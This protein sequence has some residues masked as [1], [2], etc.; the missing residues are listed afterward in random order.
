[1]ALTAAAAGEPDLT[2][3]VAQTGED[4]GRLARSSFAILRALEDKTFR[5]AFSAGPS[6]PWDNL[7]PELQRP[8]VL[9][10]PREVYHIA[11]ALIAAGDPD[12]GLRALHNLV[13]LQAEDGSWPISA[14]ISGGTHWRGLALDQL[15]LPILLAWRLGVADRLDFDPYPTLIRPAAIKILETGPATEFDRWDQAARL[16]PSSVGVAVAGLLVAAEFA[17]DAHEPAASDHME[18]VADYWNSQIETWC[19]SKP[20]AAYVTVDA[21]GQ[22]SLGVE[23]LDLVRYGLRSPVDPKV[24]AS[25]DAVDAVLK[26][27]TPHG[28]AWKRYEG[29]RYGDGEDGRPWDGDGLG[30][31]WPMLTAERAAYGVTAGLVSSRLVRAVEQFGGSIGVLP[32]QVWDGPD[33]AGWGLSHGGP[34]SSAAPYGAAHAQYLKLLAAIAQ[35]QSPDLIEPVQ[36][37]YAE[38]DCT[39]APVIWSHRNLV[40]RIPQGRQF[41]VQLPRQAGVWFSVDGGITARLATSIDTS[42]GFWTVDLPLE[43]P[44][45]GTRLEWTID[46]GDTR[47]E[48]TYAVEVDSLPGMPNHLPTR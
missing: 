29:D 48:V 33:V 30:R 28:P 12:A 38:R 39:Q 19:Y 13:G 36:R 3:A 4:G 5:G 24:I 16:S 45:P 20:R 6:S 47:E 1:E 41:R 7:V 10:W 34:T 23:F 18:A 26:V 46:Y 11:T 40:S 44:A 14:G 22:H 32:E 37:R 25:L 8:Y 9:V 31:G 43:L 27:E 17:R 35:G 21:A 15:A 2:P 42:L